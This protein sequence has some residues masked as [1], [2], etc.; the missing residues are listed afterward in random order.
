MAA[1]LGGH[2]DVAYFRSSEALSQI[3]AGT[4]R[5]LAVSSA[6]RADA[7]PDVPTFSELGYDIVHAQIRGLVMPK[8]VEPDV[9]AFWENVL[10]QVAESKEWRE[11]YVDRFHDVPDYM[12][13]EEFGKAI[14][15]T[16]ER[17]ERRKLGRASWRERVWHEV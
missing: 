1:M 5:P 14:V 12:D 3:Q 8:D 15:Q 6:E 16:S 10:G 13:S 4:L 17:Y 9:V 2:V 11:Q 7:A